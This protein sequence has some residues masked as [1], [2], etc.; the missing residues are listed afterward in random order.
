MSAAPEISGS[1]NLEAGGERESKGDSK[2]PDEHVVDG[3]PKEDSEGE[4]IQEGVKRV[5]AITQAWN[6]KALAITC[7]L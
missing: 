2:L 6:Y 1:K 4:R 7:G 5:E 3:E